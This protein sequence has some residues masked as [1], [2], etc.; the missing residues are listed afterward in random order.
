MS[1][2]FSHMTMSL[3]GYI[4]QPDDQIGELFDWYSAGEV[5]DQPQRDRHLRRG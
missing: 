4:A 1:K 2:I 5:T 3:D